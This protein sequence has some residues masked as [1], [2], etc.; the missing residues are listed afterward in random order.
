MSWTPSPDLL[1]ASDLAGR[2]TPL[3]HRHPR[4]A[5]G[6]A[7]T[8]P[9]QRRTQSCPGAALSCTHLRSA[10]RV[11]LLRC[12]KLITKHHER[13]P[14]TSL[15]ARESRLVTAGWHRQ[16]VTQLHLGGGTPPSCGRRTAGLMGSAS[17]LRLAGAECSTGVAH[18]RRTR[19]PLLARSASN[20]HFGVHDFDSGCSSG[21]RIQP[22]ERW[23]LYAST[24]GGLRFIQ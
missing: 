11:L 21:H 14:T 18:H 3:Y 2:A 4:R 16:P 17:Q 6:H 20:D 22:F 13:A 8:A 7:W 19:W 24:G 9:V 1:C 12:T 10:S 5:F 23:R 15:P